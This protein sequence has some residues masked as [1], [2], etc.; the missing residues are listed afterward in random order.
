MLTMKTLFLSLVAAALIILP[1]G[2]Q[3]PLPAEALAP[4]ITCAEPVFDFGDKVN[5]DFVEHDYPIRN[6]GTLSLEIRGV[7]A[8]CGCTAVKPSQDVIPPGGEAAIHARLD[9]RGRGGLQAKT[10]TVLSNDPQTPSLILQLK[11]NAVQALRAQPSTIF[12]G[13]IGPDGVRSRTFEIVSAQGPMQIKDFRADNPGL[14][15]TPIP[16]EAGADGSIHRFELKLADSLPEG[17]VKGS[18]FVQTDLAGQ[19]GLTIPVAA[20]IVTTPE[21]APSPAQ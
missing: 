3:E 11:G 20:F 21:P 2:A 9:L 5:T 4:K 19:P 12:F 18:V 10:I 16:A 7:Q 13:R 6:E 15:V 14:L 17:D 1:A 8:S